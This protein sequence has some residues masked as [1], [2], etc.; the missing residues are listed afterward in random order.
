[1]ERGIHSRRESKIGA[2]CHHP[3]IA[4][5]RLVIRSAMMRNYGYHLLIP[6]AILIP[7]ICVWLLYPAA[8]SHYKHRDPSYGAYSIL[9]YELSHT[10]PR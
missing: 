9:E 6:S 10:H 7:L 1:M 4:E 3:I 5:E 2:I 8:I